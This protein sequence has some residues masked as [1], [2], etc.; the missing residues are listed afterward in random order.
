MSTTATDR[1]N[2]IGDVAIKAPCVAATTAAITLN[3]EQT[4]DGVACVTGDRV[5]VKNQASSVA[6]GIYV[7]DTGDW[8]RSTD[9][10]GSY[11]CANGTLIKVNSG[12]TASGFWYAVG[13]DPI[14]VG[15]DAV[16]FSQASTVLAVVSAFMQTML[17]DPDAATARATLAAVGTTTYTA[18]GSLLVASAAST[19]A[20]LAVGA[21]GSILMAR[22]AASQGLAY[23]SPFS[24]MITGLTY[25]N[26]AV[27]ATNDLDIAAGGAMDATGAYWMTLT[28][29]TKQSD[30]AWAVGTNQG[31][32]DTGAVGNSDYFIWL[33]ARSDTGVVDV[34]YS[35][36]STSPTM[37]ASYDF[38]R[39]IGWF[40]RVGGTI[41]AFTTYETEGGGIEHMW[42]VPTLDINLANTLTTTR[43]TDA[44]KVPL[45]FSVEAHVN[46]G[47]ADV[48]GAVQ[49]W[50]YCPDQTDAAPSGS[51]APGANIEVTSAGVTASRQMRIRTSAAGLIAARSTQATVDLYI[52]STMGFRWARR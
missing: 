22:S 24:R 49:N 35:L 45:A 29:I 5:L 3:G 18:K 15:T 44:L 8:E 38:K 50:F 17:D 31:G 9:F 28:A 48:S 43:R 16:T 30:V 7:V 10:D 32:L 36:S 39:L 6:N 11:D 25:A 42:T 21:N 14:Q 33:I 40:K 13:T 46:I 4:I 1:T 26:S 12:S 52:A 20:N 34:L 19:P 23:V 37:P 27:D 2:R 41:V 51:V 47:V